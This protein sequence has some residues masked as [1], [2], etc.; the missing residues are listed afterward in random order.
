MVG[1]NSEELKKLE[2]WIYYYSF[3]KKDASMSQIKE[4]CV[5]ALTPMN[6]H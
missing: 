6:I 4:F 2:D 5:Q 3:T 1:H